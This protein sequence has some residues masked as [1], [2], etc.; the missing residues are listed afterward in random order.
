[1]LKNE[2][3]MTLI[4]ATLWIITIAIMVIL[5][6]LSETIQDIQDTDIQHNSI[7]KLNSEKMAQQND[8]YPKR[9]TKPINVV[10]L[11]V[12]SSWL[13]R[14]FVKSIQRNAHIIF[15]AGFA[16]QGVSIHFQ[17]FGQMELDYSLNIKLYEFDK[18][19]I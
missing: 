1:M 12:M 6:T 8:I 7:M 10:D 14:E 11:R 17:L 18:L 2:I 19:E 9:E 16:S 5:K 3:I 13:D 15:L 4:L